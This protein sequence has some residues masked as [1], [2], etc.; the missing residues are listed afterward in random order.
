VVLAVLIAM[1]PGGA[2]GRQQEAAAAKAERLIVELGDASK[3]KRDEAARALADL[4]G[5][6]DNKVESAT[7]SALTA[8]MKK[9]AE[10]AVRRGRGRLLAKRYRP[11][12]AALLGKLG[13]DNSDKREG[14]PR[15]RVGFGTPALPELG[16]ARDHGV[17]EPR[18]R[19]RKAI[20]AVAPQEVDAA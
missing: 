10:A 9:H 6:K 20:E 7:R 3:Q 17:R 15:N 19:A 18:R 1:P 2:A 8:A 12:R 13:D 14:A 5:A 4:L 16:A 11:H